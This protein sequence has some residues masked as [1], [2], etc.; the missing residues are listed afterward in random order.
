MYLVII[1]NSIFQF[2]DVFN[3]S[4]ES[5]SGRK[6]RK[7]QAE[8]TKKQVRIMIKQ[9]GTLVRQVKRVLINEG[10]LDKV[11]ELETLLFGG[12]CAQ[13]SIMRDEISALIDSSDLEILLA[14]T[15]SVKQTLLENIDAVES[16]RLSFRFWR[17]LA[18]WSKNTRRVTRVYLA[19]DLSGR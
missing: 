8:M 19:L 16:H 13:A 4:L 3:N 10:L 17:F 14:N 1:I 15:Y 2:I 11:I 18:M 5:G 12:N 6:R 7:R 9:F